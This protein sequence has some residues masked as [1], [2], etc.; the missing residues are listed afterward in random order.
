V[1]AE[2]EHRAAAWCTDPDDYAAAVS[3][4]TG[5]P[6]PVLLPGEARRAALWRDVVDQQFDAAAAPAPAR[7]V[8]AWGADAAAPARL[9][10][11]AT[12]SALLENADLGGIL[13]EARRAGPALVV[14]GAAPR[15]R[16]AALA[17]ISAAA[18]ASGRPF[19]V[20]TGR[21]PAGLA[22]SVAKALLAPRPSLGGLDGFD[23]PSHRPADDPTRPPRVLVKEL[24]RPALVKLLRTHGEGGHA[25]LPGAVVCGVLDDAE[26]PAAPG[27]GCAREPRRCKRAAAAGR[28][29]V[30]ADEIAAPVVGF[31]CCN[32]FNV[33]GELYPSAV[34]VALG[35]IDGWAGAVIA[36]IRPLIAPDTVVE[37]LRDGLAHGEQLGALTARLNRI[38]A[39]LGQPDAFILN[40]DPH[41][42]VSGATEGAAEFAESGNGAAPGA[43]RITVAG[44]SAVGR[45]ARDA[46]P[47]DGLAASEVW[48]VR[49]L[50]QLE[51]CRRLRRAL[52][53]WL[54]GR[55]SEAE[56]ADLLARRL[57][58]MERSAVNALKWVQS[59]PTGHSRD[60][61]LR[62]VA[63]IRLSLGQIDRALVRLLLDAR[64]SVDPF[65]LG[66]YDLRL[67]KAVEGPACLRC[68]SPTEVQTFG[69]AG[70]GGD[71]HVARSCLVCG[72]LAASRVGAPRLT[73]RQQSIRV[74]AGE[75]VELRVRLQIPEQAR[76]ITSAAQLYIRVFD[77]AND[78]CLYERVEAV[79]AR[80]ADLDVT[81]TVPQECGMDLHS[82]R[83]AVACGLDFAYARGRF[84]VLPALETE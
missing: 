41:L 42:A 10:A 65:D 54:A 80:T 62:S 45:D 71:R 40:G 2:E 4:Y 68:G 17:R 60:A 70:T 59:R 63:L 74:R 15:M 38:C 64:A 49:L 79:P 20:L 27:L 11:S 56:D 30:F 8:A 76:Q 67:L 31:V 33:A 48:L 83:L 58:A 69:G 73:I 84:A 1:I 19:G 53:S 37:T 44:P 36:P 35:L 57:D 3:R 81:F 39:D 72:P 32:G 14:V 46:I 82:A 7:V 66:H 22:F 6:P 34:S 75:Q 21:D 16:V 9:Y 13:E 18:R 28:L 52:D 29:V 78:L 24:I 43:D 61:L 5:G 26:F 77:K 23:A 51:R 25:K 55:G 12:G 50:R 47:D